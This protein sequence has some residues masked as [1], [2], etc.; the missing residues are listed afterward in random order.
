[1]QTW[2]VKSDQLAV[3]GLFAYLRRSTRLYLSRGMK[4][5]DG[6]VMDFLR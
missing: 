3:L 2:Q 6:L 4:A 1:M 5:V